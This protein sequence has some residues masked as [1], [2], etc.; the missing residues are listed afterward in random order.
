M[1]QRYIYKL[2]FLG[3]LMSIAFF[4]APQIMAQEQYAFAVTFIDKDDAPT[5]QEASAYLSARAM[6]RRA[7][8]QIAIEDNDRPVSAA[9]VQSVLV[10]SGGKYHLASKW[11]NLCV[12]LVDDTSMISAVRNLN[13]VSSV[14]WVGYY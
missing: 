1:L 12:V 13:F 7:K 6:A 14:R 2:Y 11:L 8:Y 4:Y 3:L 10:A 9:Y 5:I